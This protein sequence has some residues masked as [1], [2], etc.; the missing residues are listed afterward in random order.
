MRVCKEAIA[1]NR[2][3]QGAFSAGLKASKKALASNRAQV[4]YIAKDAEARIIGEI[5]QI[6]KDNGIETVMAETMKGLG[7]ACGIQVGAAVAVLYC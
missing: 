2:L 1:L 6:C 3:K 4:I 5:S 7:D